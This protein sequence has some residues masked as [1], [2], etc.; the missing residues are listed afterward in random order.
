MTATDLP[1]SSEVD[2]S[3]KLVTD[4][5]QRV[6]LW[7]YDRDREQLVTLYNK[8][9]SSQWNSVTD[10]DWATDVDPEELVRTSPQQNVI[11]Q[12]ARAAAEVEGSPLAA[13]GEREFLRSASSRSRPACRSSCTASR[14]R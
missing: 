14:A 6:F 1:D 13:W 12:L 10:L 4:N 7:N 8:G 2:A 9:M 5:A 11:V 3:I